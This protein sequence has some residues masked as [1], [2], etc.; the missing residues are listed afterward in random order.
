MGRGSK[1]LGHGRLL[2]ERGD[3]KGCRLPRVGLLSLRAV[4]GFPLVHQKHSCSAE[5]FCC[6]RD[7]T[8]KCV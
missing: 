1:G 7:E 6:H 2:P 3:Q 8:A 5:F 4:T